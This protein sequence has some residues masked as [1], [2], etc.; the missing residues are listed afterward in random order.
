MTCY[1]REVFVGFAPRFKV[2]YTP[3]VLVFSSKEVRKIESVAVDI[4]TER[5]GYRSI[6]FNADLRG[7][8]SCVLASG[9]FVDR[10]SC[11]HL[12]SGNLIAA[13]ASENVAIWIALQLGNARA[14]PAAASIEKGNVLPLACAVYKLVASQ[15]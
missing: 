14:I 4:A 15:R 10:N 6:Y 1:V 7:I 9:T 12:K 3:A 5:C 13:D 8:A 2:K 11:R